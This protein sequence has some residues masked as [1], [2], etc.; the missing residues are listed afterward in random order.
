MPVPLAA[1]TMARRVSSASFIGRDARLSQIVQRVDAL[2]QVLGII[3]RSVPPEL[4]PLCQGVAWVGS[5]LMVAV[6][7]SA[8]ATRLRMLAPTIIA[9]LQAANWHATAV[10]PRVQVALQ[11]DKP[12][13][14]SQ[15]SSLPDAALEAFS[16]LAHDVADPALR[17][18]VEALLAHQRKR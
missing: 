5:E 3:R 11:Q 9:A 13:K 2:N 17:Q 8:A 14:S 18:A 7:H 12:E 6:P 15:L 1:K 16:D 10:R 4:A